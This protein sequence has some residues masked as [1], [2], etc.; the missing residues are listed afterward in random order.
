VSKK[1]FAEHNLQGKRFSEPLKTTNKTPATRAANAIYDRIGRGEARPIQ[2]RVEWKELV[3]GY[4]ALK[5]DKNRAPK[6]IEKY[7]Y[8]L[9]E[10]QA[11][12]ERKRRLPA[13][14]FKWA[15][16]K[17]KLLRENPVAGEDVDE[18]EPTEQP[19]FTPGQVQVLLEKADPHEGAIFAVMVYTGMRFG[20]V[21]LSDAKTGGLKGF[22]C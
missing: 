3:D 21:P 16:G 8:V 18:P 17:G 22:C 1:W 6:T 9:H 5:R 20:E 10:L 15:A 2:R 7:E 11:F 12:A 4:L 19:C 13:Q 14:L